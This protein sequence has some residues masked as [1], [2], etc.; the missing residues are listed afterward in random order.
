MLLHLA[1]GKIFSICSTYNSGRNFVSSTDQPLDK[2]GKLASRTKSDGKYYGGVSEM[3][4]KVIE[5][6]NLT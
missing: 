4:Q 6:G 3:A 1:S 2:I 5:G